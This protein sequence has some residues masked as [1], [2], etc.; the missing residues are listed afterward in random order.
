MSALEGTK[1]RPAAARVAGL[2]VVLLLATGLFINYVDRGNLATAAPLIKD[3][4]KLT[5]TEVGLLL[6]AFYWT[7][8][9]AQFVAGPLAERNPYRALSLGLLLW[10]GATALTGLAQGFLGLLALRLVLGLG[11]S[12]AFPS[13]SKIIAR[14]VAP[15]RLGLANGI[16]GVG[17][18]LGPALGVFLGGHMMAEWGWR[19]VFLAFGLGSLIWLLPWMLATR[20]LNTRA[21]AAEA[22]EA[23]AP[24]LF[25]LMA[26]RELWGCSLGHFSSNYAFYF[27]VSWI[28]TYLVKAQGFDLHGMANLTG[29]IY[30]VYAAVCL[31]VGQLTDLWA[32]AGASANLIRK[33]II[34]SG[35]GLMALT[36]LGCALGRP[37]LS[38]ACLFLSSIAFGIG[39]SNI[40]A[41]AQILAGP[42][43]TGKWI[44]FQNFMG[45]IPGIVAPLVTGWLVD[46][47]HGFEAAFAVAC[48][49]AFLGFIGWGLMIRKVAPIEWSGV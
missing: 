40:F 12:A 28:P 17:L 1:P 25:R 44:G 49:A 11:E 14:D 7:Y 19:A 43:A 15:A 47:T 2:G 21:R 8:A 9:P 46:R 16:V 35:H 29:L 13:I 48:A 22:D 34:L 6:S 5:A 3:Q 30:L 39:T 23:P 33:S 24:S 45:N 20:G 18:A 41:I 31:I 32:R 27:V 38:I 10:A 36:M 42:R 26:R 4:L 37:Q